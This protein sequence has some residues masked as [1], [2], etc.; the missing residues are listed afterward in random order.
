MSYSWSRAHAKRREHKNKTEIFEE[1]AQWEDGNILRACL[2]GSG[3]ETEK[4][5]E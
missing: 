3:W 2:P 4:E 5:F 1:L